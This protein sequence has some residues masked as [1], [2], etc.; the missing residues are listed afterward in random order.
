MGKLGIRK[1]L[2]K[3]FERMTKPKKPATAKSKADIPK[4]PVHH[5]P[6]TEEHSQVPVSQGGFR[7]LYC[8]K[9][10]AGQGKWSRRQE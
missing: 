5:V 6:F 9:C 8:A 1:K 2:Q 10:R 4:C 7:H 3:D